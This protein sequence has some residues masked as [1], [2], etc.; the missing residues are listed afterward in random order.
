MLDLEQIRALS[1]QPLRPF[2]RGLLREYLQYKVLEAIAELPVADRLRFMGGTCIHMV[3]G[4]PRFSE[5]LDFDNLDITLEDF[6]SLCRDVRHALELDGYRAECSVS[7]AGALSASLRFPGLLHAQGL[8]DH[9]EEKLLIKIDTEP[10]R[11]GYLPDKVVINRYDVLLRINVVPVD[12]LLAQKIHCALARRRAM[13]RDFFD[14][15]HLIGRTAP[16]MGYLQEK[17]GIGTHDEV[18]DRLL[19]RWRSLDTRALVL[20][21]KPFLPD[22]R[23]INRLELFADL[24][25]SWKPEARQAP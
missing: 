6:N 2:G 11:F 24:V 13:G 1:P 14:I 10:Q 22:A 21:V 20:D 17:T 12:I 5:Y 4:S 15:L 19:A 23:D 3:H 9:P 18:R 25:E 7:A 16:N 8:S